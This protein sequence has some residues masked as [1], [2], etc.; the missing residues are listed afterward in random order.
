MKLTRLKKSLDSQMND[1]FNRLR[2][3]LTSK[4]IH[5]NR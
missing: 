4:T 3:H 1:Y 2:F 5:I